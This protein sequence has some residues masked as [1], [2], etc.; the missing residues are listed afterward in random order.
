[1]ASVERSSADK[2][3]TTAVQQNDRFSVS[4]QVPPAGHAVELR[5]IGEVGQHS[6]AAIDFTA[7][8]DDARLGGWDYSG[9]KPMIITLSMRSCRHVEARWPQIPATR[10][11]IREKLILAGDEYTR[12][13]VTPGT[14]VDVDEDGS[15][16]TSDGGWI[17]PDGPAS[18]LARLE[19]IAKIS[20]EW[21]TTTHKVA[22][23]STYDLRGEDDIR[24][25]QLVRT[26]G[27]TTA[28]PASGHAE[29][30]NAIVSQI[31]VQTPRG[32]SGSAPPEARMHVVTWAGEL[33]PSTQGPPLQVQQRRQPVPPSPDSSM[34]QRLQSGQQEMAPGFTSPEEA[35]FF[36]N[37]TNLRNSIMGFGQ[38]E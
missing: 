31:T 38:G 33:D 2:T 26:I 5:V 16:V 36:H 25:G 10:D 12:D 35:A 37:D 17:P 34:L 21:Y 28:E 6:I 3:N 19:A 20:A 14:V 4:V 27:G 9:S 23:L 22:T 24:L 32:G 18:N 11:A 1:M 8:A 29:E 13:Y 15:L 30:I 7:L